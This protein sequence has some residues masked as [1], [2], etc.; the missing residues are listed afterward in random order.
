MASPLARALPTRT[1]LGAAVAVV[2][3]LLMGASRR[4]AVRGFRNGVIDL[5]G[6]PGPTIALGAVG[7]ALLG[8]MVVVVL[9][10]DLWRAGS[11]LVP[12]T[13]SLATAGRGS[14]AP[15]AI[16][17]ATL[18]L[19]T[20]AWT[21][22]LVGAFRSSRPA[23]A[24]AGVVYVAAA[25]AWA[26]GSAPAVTLLLAAPLYGLLG[27]RPEERSAALDFAVVFTLVASVH[28]LGQHRELADLERFGVPVL[29]GQLELD[30]MALRGLVLPFLLLIGIEMAVLGYRASESSVGLVQDR[31][32]RAV[33]LGLLALLLGWRLYVDA[34]GAIAGIGLQPA[35]ALG[36]LGAAGMPLAAAGAWAIA[37]SG[38][39]ANAPE[40]TAEELLEA[41]GRTVFPL[42]L[43]F[44]AV[45][46]AASV[47]ALAALG[48]PAAGPGAFAHAAAVAGVDLAERL[49]APWQALVLLASLALAIHWS[50]N[51]RPAAAGFLA[52]FAL[53]NLWVEATAPGRPLA[54]LGWEGD[55]EELWWVALFS[56]TGV[57]WAV[58]GTLTD[59]RLGA[60]LVLAILVW[61]LRQTQFLDDPYT[62]FFFGYSGI[63]FI[64]F[65]ILWDMLTRGTWANGSSAGLPRP[66]RLF[67]YIG[68]GLLTVTVVNW[69]VTTHDLLAVEQLTGGSAVAGLYRFGKP[70]IAAIVFATLFPGPTAAASAARRGHTHPHPL[71]PGVAR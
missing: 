54:A 49:V 13:S 5:R 64:A 56:A 38:R 60:L 4:W 25:S 44:V 10:N 70:M 15:A 34:A 69:V 2:W 71:T 65:G 51:G 66:G 17:P 40:P 6:L 7:L 33:L 22:L 61:L 1:T 12:L 47:L 31:A 14:T 58:R 30:V 39:R 36:Y 42:I 41:T 11:E 45:P 19:M 23:A 18:F 9:F 46:L 62:P 50:R 37:R 55:A 35:A 59:A 8:G 20:A 16:V 57:A 3:L 63:G 26:G 48:L 43:A 21:F 32:P 27:R 28:L 53:L 29:L 24:A 52:A 67:L 68:Y